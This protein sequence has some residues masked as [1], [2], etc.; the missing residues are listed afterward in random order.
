M[1]QNDRTAIV[2]F[3]VQN[4]GSA[5][6]RSHA[7]HTKEICGHILHFDHRRRFVSSRSEFPRCS[8]GVGRNRLQRVALAAPIKK[9]GEGDIL[10]RSGARLLRCRF[11]VRKHHSLQRNQSF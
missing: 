8:V 7:Q 1:T 2:S 3:V 10:D 9:V 4:K 11:P 5:E 6:H